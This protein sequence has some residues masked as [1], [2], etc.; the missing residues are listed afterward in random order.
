MIGSTGPPTIHSGTGAM[1]M[2]G[3][4]NLDQHFG[5]LS[6]DKLYNES[7]DLRRQAGAMTETSPIKGTIQDFDKRLHLPNID[8][9]SMQEANKDRKSIMLQTQMQRQEGMRRTGAFMSDEPQRAGSNLRNFDVI[10]GHMK[11]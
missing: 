1:N 5:R 3:G 8:K 11:T 2:K 7:P 10:E 9:K 6:T 4:V